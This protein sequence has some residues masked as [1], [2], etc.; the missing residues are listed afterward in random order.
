MLFIDILH[1]LREI[2]RKCV[3]SILKGRRENIGIW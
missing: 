3:D 2:K 1:G